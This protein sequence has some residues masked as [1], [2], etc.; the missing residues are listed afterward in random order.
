MTGP[1]IETDAD[2]AAGARHL[3][4][5]EPRFGPAIAAIGPIPLRRREPGFAALLRILVGQQVSVA[6][7]D[8]IWGRVAAAEMTSPARILAADDGELRALGLSRPKIRYARAIAEAVTAGT[9]CLDSC[10][11][12]PVEDAMAMLTAVTGIGNWTAEIYLMF[13]VGHPEVFAPKD[14]ALQE[15]ARLLLDL[16]ER[17]AP[18]ELAVLAEAWSP[19][20]AVA[21]RVLWAYYHVE[22]GRAGLGG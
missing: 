12:A 16:P 8:G 19:W 11:T 15:A 20:R 4:S 3:C 9:L 5:V 17:P 1:R 13:C 10:A 21:A 14:L 7:A 2:L 6:A 18:A 22:K